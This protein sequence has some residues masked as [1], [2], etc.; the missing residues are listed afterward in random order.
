[1]AVWVMNHIII[2]IM[3]VFIIVCIIIIISPLTSITCPIDS[4]GDGDGV[5]LYM[6]PICAINFLFP[7]N[8]DIVIT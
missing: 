2:F 5:Q 1:M 7:R 3:D 4:L 8:K 6:Q